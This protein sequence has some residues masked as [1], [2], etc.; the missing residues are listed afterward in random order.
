MVHGTRPDRVAESWTELDTIPISKS[1]RVMKLLDIRA[2]ELKS[3]VHEV[4]DRIW[5]TLVFVDIE[6]SSMTIV[7]TRNGRT[8]YPSCG[9]AD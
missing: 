2:F 4:F 6:N 3:D 1:S 8:R 5:N 9:L 7:E